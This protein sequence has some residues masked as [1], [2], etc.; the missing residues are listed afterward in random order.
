MLERV[1]RDV[2]RADQRQHQRH[3]AAGG[4]GRGARA[5]RP[6]DRIFL[7]PALFARVDAVYRQRDSLGLDPESRRLVEY[8]HDQFVHAGAQLPE[9]EKAKLKKLN[10]EE[11]SLRPAS[12]TGC[13]PPGGE[14][15]L[16]VDDRAALAGLSDSQ[17]AAAAQAARER[18]LDG[19]YLIALQN[20]THQPVLHVPDQP[21][22]P[23]EALPG[24]REPGSRGDEND[25]RDI[26]QRLAQLRAEKARLLGF[27]NYAGW[28]L[29][30]Q[31]AGNPAT[32]RPFSPAEPAT[33]Q[34]ARAR[35]PTSRS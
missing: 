1:Q 27:A 33:E 29:E 35:P 21:R 9:A 22:H 2:Q 13:W 31:M 23:G 28:K 8:Y 10:K 20:T 24:V 34:A 18:G 6:P 17:I 19:K 16:V 3:P 11:A 15:A 7:D 25:T 32:W 30:D 12:T 5:G 4:A 26:V 14:G